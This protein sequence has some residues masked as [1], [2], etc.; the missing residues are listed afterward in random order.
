MS[1]GRTKPLRGCLSLR[2]IPERKTSARPRRRV[3]SVSPALCTP[4]KKQSIYMDNNNNFIFSNK[5]THWLALSAENEDSW[6]IIFNP[7]VD[8]RGNHLRGE[9]VRRVSNMEYH[10]ECPECMKLFASKVIMRLHIAAKHGGVKYNCK[11]CPK[12]RSNITF[13][14]IISH[15]SGVLLSRS[16]YALFRNSSTYPPCIRIWRGDTAALWGRMTRRILR[17]TSLSKASEIGLLL[18]YVSNI[19]WL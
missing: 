14:W 6:R 9:R 1:Q 12:V 10:H 15:P 4:E 2:S 3:T 19:T 8:Q 17:R 13:I 11:Q 18:L 7:N 5:I 16:P